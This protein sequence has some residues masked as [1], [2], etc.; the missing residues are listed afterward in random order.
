[1]KGKI[2]RQQSLR[3]NRRGLSP[4][5]STVIITSAVVVMVLVAMMY[6]NSYLNSNL[7]RNEFA[8]NK[9]FMLTTSLQLDDIAWIIGRAQTVRYSAK[10]GVVDFQ[11][12]ALNYSFE[13]KTNGVWTKVFDLGTGVVTFDMYSDNPLLGNS[14]FQNISSTSRSINQ[15]GPSAPIANVYAIERGTATGQNLAHIVVVP[16]VRMMTSTVGTQNYVKFYLPLLQSGSISSSFQSVTLIGDPGT[17]YV[18]SGVSEVRLNST[19][20]ASAKGF[21]SGFY[22]FESNSVTISLSSGAV[23]DF[24]LGKVTVSLG[25]YV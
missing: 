2:F 4:A 9:Q 20:P 8:V 6:S 22:N 7:S 12:N 3:R 15:T 18:Y 21:D 19:F 5:I 13:I 24:Y 23:V 25:L 10:Y 16:T 11:N 14:H 1:M 17:K